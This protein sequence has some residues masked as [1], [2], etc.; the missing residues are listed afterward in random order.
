MST[1][2][3]V[4]LEVFWFPLSFRRAYVLLLVRFYRG[5]YASSLL[6]THSAE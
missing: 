1:I 2:A 5:Y 3:R 4:S 6:D